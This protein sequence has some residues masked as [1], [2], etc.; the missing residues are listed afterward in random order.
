MGRPRLTPSTGR[1]GQEITYAARRATGRTSSSRNPPNGSVLTRMALP[2]CPKRD[3]GAAHPAGHRD[4]IEA[5]RISP[6]RRPA[7]L[8]RRPWLNRLD[9]HCCRLGGPGGVGN[10]PWQSHGSGGHAEPAPPDGSEAEK[11][12]DD[13]G[14]RVR[15]DREAEPCAPRISA[16]LIPISSCRRGE[17]TAR[18]AGQRSVGL[19]NIFDRPAG[20]LGRVRPSAETTPAVTVASK[21]SGAPIAIASWPCL[22]RALSPMRTAVR[23]SRRSA[24]RRGRYRH[25]S[26]APAHYLSPTASRT[27]AEVLH[28][29]RLHLGSTKHLGQEYP[30]DPPFRPKN[31]HGLIDA[32]VVAVNNGD[33]AGVFRPWS[34]R[35]PPT[36]TRLFSV[37]S[38]SNA[39]RL[40]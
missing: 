7:L 29:A 14:N 9:D 39:S 40:V 35:R 33:P 22:S 24:A 4:A 8:R 20:R 37:R 34:T 38:V 23:S 13:E 27:T 15:R 2:I 3:G 25:R 30:L 17:R 28:Q 18:A 12:A 6:L 5:S 32:N 16:V 36:L 26:R 10:P 11:L 1:A 31:S 19:D 21:P